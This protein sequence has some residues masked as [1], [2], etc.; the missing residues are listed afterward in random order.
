MAT[1]VYIATAYRYGWLNNGHYL[2][3]ADTDERATLNAAKAECHSRGGKYG[4]SVHR[5]DGADSIEVAYFPSSYGE[6][7]AHHNERITLFD[8]LG[9]T[10]AT[11]IEN[12]DEKPVLN[13]IREEYQREL[14]ISKILAEPPMTAQEADKAY[15]ESPAEPM[16]REEI[17]SIVRRVV[18]E[19]L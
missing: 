15:D 8:R 4:V 9:S 13:W 14:R 18:N 10:V 3:W 6:N 1:P 19:P 5:V 12:P 17:D 11:A 2:V 7:S 16:T